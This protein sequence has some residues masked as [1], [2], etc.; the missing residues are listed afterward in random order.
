ML[1]RWEYRKIISIKPRS[2]MNA[3]IWNELLSFFDT[4]ND[5]EVL[6]EKALGY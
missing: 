3:R 5:R 4:V 6:L 2:E 1:F